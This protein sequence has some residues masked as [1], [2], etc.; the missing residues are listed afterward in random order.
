MPEKRGAGVRV[1]CDDC[2]FRQ[3]LLCALDVEQ[4]C[5][6]FRATVGRSRRPET[7][8]QARLVPVVQARVEQA[9]IVSAVAPAAVM[10]L[11]VVERF[12]A[13]AA[14]ASAPVPFAAYEP[15]SNFSLGETAPPL[16][17][18]VPRL[19]AREVVQAVSH[20]V[21]ARAPRA[22]AAGRPAAVASVV[23]PVAAPG[24]AEQGS[25][26]LASAASSRLSRVARRVAQRYP[27]ASAQLPGLEG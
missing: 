18:D 21:Q 7:P 6:T 8:K 16:S 9:E 19:P 12:Q 3:E 15:E 24:E 22:A 11:P 26:P 4:V 10:E 1:S 23:V 13:P 25:L 20:A 5:P 2:Y 27:Q 17:E 14:G